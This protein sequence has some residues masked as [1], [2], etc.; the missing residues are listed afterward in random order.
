MTKSKSSTAIAVTRLRRLTQLKYM[1]ENH[2]EIFPDTRLDMS[3]FLQGSSRCGFAA[4]AL[5]SAA[6]YPSF[7]D[8]GLE[9]VPLDWSPYH[10][11]PRYRGHMSY[12]AGAKFFHITMEESYFL[13]SPG[14]YIPHCA[15]TNSDVVSHIN[16]LLE[17]YK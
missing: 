11:A 6:A 14:S 8:E 15:I 2:T 12:Y 3:V 9:L 4:C 10:L 13:F 1:M 5:G 17:Q 7:R 16:T